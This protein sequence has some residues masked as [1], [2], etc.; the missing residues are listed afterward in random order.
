MSSI[1]LCN[2]CNAEISAPD[3]TSPAAGLEQLRSMHTLSIAE[4]TSTRHTVANFQKHLGQYDA[5][6]SSLE[7]ILASLK[8][9]RSELQKYINDKC[10]MLAPIRKLP[11]D[12]ISDILYWGSG[13]YN[14]AITACDITAHT[15][16]LSQVCSFWREIALS[17]PSLWSRIYLVLRLRVDHGYNAQGG[18]GVRKL[19][20]LYLSRSRDLP[21]TLSVKPLNH[22]QRYLLNLD[23]SL[24]S[25]L[26]RQRFRWQSVSLDLE[27]LRYSSYL[28]EHEISYPALEYLDLQWNENAL[29]PNL[30]N[31]SWITSLSNKAPRLRRL[32]LTNSS[33][34]LLEQLDIKLDQIT[35]LRSNSDAWVN[36]QWSTQYFR[37]LE[38]FSTV[39]GFD[40]EDFRTSPVPI[41]KSLTLTSLSIVIDDILVASKLLTSLFYP[42][43]T[44][45][46]I[47]LASGR[48]GESLDE[49][50][51]WVKSLKAMLQN[52]PGLRTLTSS[53]GS[54]LAADQIL[55]V[56]TSMP[57]LTH[58]NLDIDCDAINNDF[59]SALTL[60]LLI[61][62]DFGNETESKTPLLPQLTS[63]TLT[64]TE[65]YSRL[66]IELPDP[67]VIVD[68]VLSRRQGL[69]A[70]VQTDPDS[71]RFSAAGSGFASTTGVL[72][73][74]GFSA[75]A[76]ACSASETAWATRLRSS[77]T[78][79]LLVLHDR[80]FTCQLDLGEF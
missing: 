50:A 57:S 20:K 66:T 49:I 17:R 52:S 56:F 55:D 70:G 69:T 26:R 77:V 43:L 29:P 63:L 65:L 15:L 13:E 27:C 6:I 25:I 28:S 35:S 5:E 75:R 14:L 73:H 12:V 34:R 4:A 39:I 10:S 8:E 33:Q 21:L 64:L 22:S 59:F 46:D 58:L 60:P 79:R 32:V 51:E 44:T 37:S 11:L 31:H 47:T 48:W 53:T 2:R 7:S 45:L 1:R 80:P 54:T 30:R 41:N 61:P 78:K 76:R 71:L 18:K 36:G 40:S 38:H 62:A 72:Q 68:M 42:S 19:L 9:K 24:F 67:D 3:T 23:C 74:F 16:S